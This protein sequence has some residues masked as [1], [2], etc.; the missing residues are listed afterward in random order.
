MKWYRPPTTRLIEAML[1]IRPILNRP[2]NKRSRTSRS[3]PS[4]MR[5]THRAIEP[6]NFKLIRMLRRVH[7]AGRTLTL[8]N[9]NTSRKCSPTRPSIHSPMKTCRPRRVC[10]TK[11]A[12]R[13]RAWELRMLIG[14][15]LKS[16][17]SHSSILFSRV[18]KLL[19]TNMNN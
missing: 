8:L 2:P 7:L 4:A 5:V 13:H 15:T 6:F 18:S 3:E 12:M 9:S 16:M 10:L 19:L 11:M 1:A 17:K 14:C